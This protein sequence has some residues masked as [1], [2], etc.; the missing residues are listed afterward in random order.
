MNPVRNSP[1]LQKLTILMAAGGSGLRVGT[2]V[3]KQFLLLSDKP[4]YW[5]SLNLFLKMPSVD[6]IV[7]GLS[8]DRIP[9]VKKD[10]EE[11]FPGEIAS[12][13]ILL[14]EGGKRRQDTVYKGLLLLDDLPEKPEY[15]LV[16]D[17]ARPFLSQE[18]MGRLM[19][20]LSEKTAIAV[21][22]PLADTL[23]RSHSPLT[24]GRAEPG[25]TSPHI[26]ELVP[27]DHL[28]RAQTPQGAPFS[29]FLEARRKALECGDPD[30]TDEAGLLLWAGFPVRIV[31]GSE[32]NRKVTTPED[33]VWAQKRVLE[34]AGSF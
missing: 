4:M 33:L 28:Y 26:E 3:P 24:A 31:L 17:A 1:V 9:L 21:G 32:D 20:S 12:G 27:R 8:A 16:H 22:I 6:R 25:A 18:I 19:D 14:F 13:R 10:L 2:P 5:Y 30:F 15:L 29:F 7:V 34:S 23:W 11:Y